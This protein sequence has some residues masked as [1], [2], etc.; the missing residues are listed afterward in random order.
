MSDICF[1]LSFLS[2][3]WPL[4][5][6]HH[7]RTECMIEFSGPWTLAFRPLDLLAGYRDTTT[8]L[9]LN[10]NSFRILTLGRL[11][12]RQVMAARTEE[13]RRAHRG[14]LCVDVGPQ[15]RTAASRVASAAWH[16]PRLHGKL[17]GCNGRQLVKMGP[18][19]CNGLISARSPTAPSL[20]RPEFR[21]AGSV[22]GF[23]RHVLALH[24]VTSSS[25]CTDTDNAAHPWESTIFERRSQFRHSCPCLPGHW[26]TWTRAG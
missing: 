25:P 14:D 5:N 10:G 2:S 23:P 6:G 18:G 8:A 3:T 22:V 21:G 17:R 26:A 9:D 19:H 11:L 12:V 24:M 7:L 1:L 13:I 4:C 20:G 15:C 16:H